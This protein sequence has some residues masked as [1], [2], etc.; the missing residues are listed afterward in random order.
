M[1]HDHE[2]ADENTHP[3]ASHE[4]GG[5]VHALVALVE[6][7]IG[8]IRAD[9]TDAI[10]AARA[11]TDSAFHELWVAAREVWTADHTERVRQRLR[12][13][14]RVVV[15]GVDDGERT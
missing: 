6:Q 2:R 8:E 14:G 11:D 9:V 7:T 3:P 4:I 1:S 5:R 15:D 10:E 13:A 12:L